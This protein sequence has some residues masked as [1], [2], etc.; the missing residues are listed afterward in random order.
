MVAVSSDYGEMVKFSDV[1]L[2]PRQGT[3]AALALAMGHVVLT[4]FHRDNPS[5]YFVDYLKQ[6]TDMPMLVT[7]KE[8]DGKLVPDYFLRASHLPENLGETNNP[9]WKTVLVDALTNDIVAPNGSVGFRWGEDKAGTGKV[10]RW[11][12]EKRDG[13]SGREI[14]PVLS[15]KGMHDDVKAT[16]GFSDSVCTTTCT[17]LKKPSGNSGR[18]GRSISRLVSVSSSLEYNRRE[19]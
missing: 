18:M 4:E 19:P 8:H 5:Q 2:A 9:E 14:D 13:G 16:S 11:N 3:D 6:Y 1:W 12:L 10:G 7:L 17:S 15:L